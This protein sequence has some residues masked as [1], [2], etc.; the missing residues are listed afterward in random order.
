MTDEWHNSSVHLENDSSKE[1]LWEIQPTSLRIN[2][3]YVKYYLIYSNLIVNSVLPFAILIILNYFIFKRVRGEFRDLY[4]ISYILAFK[5]IWWAWW[6][7]QHY[8]QFKWA[9]YS[10]SVDFH[11]Y[12]QGLVH[13]REMLLAHI[14]LVIVFVFMF[15]HRKVWAFK[16]KS[17]PQFA[18]QR[19]VDT[20]HLGAQTGGDGQ[21]E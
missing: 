1:T 9:Q 21:G 11:R 18:Y 15:S 7:L 2:P 12:Y 14:S 16:Q 13:K 20:K 4:F 8:I 10:I 19:E 5:F 3:D 6:T 17:Y